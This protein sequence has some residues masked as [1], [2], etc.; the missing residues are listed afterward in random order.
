VV[1]FSRSMHI[2][3]GQRV[4]LRA[5]AAED[6]EALF[7]CWSHPEVAYWL[8]APLLSSVAETRELIT[9]LLSMADQEESLRW[10]IV[11]P[12]GEVI[13]T[14]GYNG[15]QLEGAYRGELGCEL[16]PD[17]WGRG[18]M[19]EALQL[20]LDYGFRVM[21]LNR[22]EVLCHPD[23]V[24]AEGLFTTLG[25]R[26]EGILREYRHTVSGFQNVVLYALLRSD[27]YINE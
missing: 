27:M 18:Y 1:Q 10:S 23:N 14:C 22:I 13:G 3:T 4:E 7:N 19:R 25:F 12:G 5:I 26:R 8:G 2:L 11:L 16:L 9:R 15:W 20:L 24:R 6:A 21:E 17:Y